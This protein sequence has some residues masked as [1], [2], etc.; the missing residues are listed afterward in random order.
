MP[1]DSESRYEVFGLAG[2]V[3]I[4]TGAN[5]NIGRSIAVTLA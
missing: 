4:V 1:P 2:R 3:A 5:R